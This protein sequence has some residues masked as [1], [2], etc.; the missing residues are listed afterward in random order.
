MVTQEVIS[1]DAQDDAENK[2]EFFNESEKR[3]H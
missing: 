2:L 3:E 1:D